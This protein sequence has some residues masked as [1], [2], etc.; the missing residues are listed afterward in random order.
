MPEKGIFNY[1]RK[2]EGLQLNCRRS[3]NGLQGALSL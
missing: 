3:Y 1:I 2:H